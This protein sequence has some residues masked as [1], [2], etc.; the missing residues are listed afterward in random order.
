[1]KKIIIASLVFIIGVVVINSYNDDQINLN[2]HTVHLK[3]GSTYTRTNPNS[4]TSDNI[5]ENRTDSFVGVLLLLLGTVFFIIIFYLISSYSKPVQSD[6]KTSLNK[7]VKK[8]YNFDNK[9]KVIPKLESNI[10]EESIDT[11]GLSSNSVLNFPKDIVIQNPPLSIK[12]LKLEIQAA[13]S[14]NKKIE[15][16]YK[17]YN[18][19]KTNRIIRPIAVGKEMESKAS[20]HILLSKG[21]VYM[22]G[23]CEL[24][25][26][27]LFFKLK[28]ISRLKTLY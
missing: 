6:V 17:D 12:A 7:S 3:N 2:Q 25:K 28:N 13:I 15:I 9:T 1:M 18:G 22:K 11:S 24:K 21:T 4:T 19:R 23:Y 26:T 27:T 20:S 16:D 14:Q 10:M 8:D 5:S